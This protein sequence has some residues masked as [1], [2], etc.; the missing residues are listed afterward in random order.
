[1]RSDPEVRAAGF[2]VD[3]AVDVLLN[4]LAVVELSLEAEHV[5]SAGR[6]QRGAASCF[7]TK[8]FA[9]DIDVHAA[10]G[11]GS[12]LGDAAVELAVEC[13]VE[14]CREESGD[15]KLV[16]RKDVRAREEFIVVLH[17][18]DAVLAV[19]NDVVGRITR[20]AVADPELLETG[21]LKNS[22]NLMEVTREEVN[23]DFGDFRGA[24][25]LSIRKWI[26]EKTSALQGDRSVSGARAPL[27]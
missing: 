21:A 15:G 25:P 5:V 16:F 17:R 27:P 26:P 3:R 8:L 9:A 12:V 1:M 23:R 14:A 10:L 13:E 4:V 11:D 18:V 6:A 22:R 19:I 20:E 7:M 2:E 24:P